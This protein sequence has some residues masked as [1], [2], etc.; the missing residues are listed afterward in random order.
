MNDK[1]DNKSS[2]ITRRDFFKATTI[3]ASGAMLSGLPL[4]ASAYVSPQET[5]KVALIGSGNRGAGAAVNALSTGDGIKLVAMADLNE[6]RLQTSYSHLNT[7]FQGTGKVDVPEEHKFVGFDAYKHAIEL[8]DVVLLC[9]YPAF[10]PL[11]F[12]EAVRQGKHVFAEKPLATDIKGVQKFFEVA[13]TAR[14]KKINVVVGLQRR[15]ETKYRE[16]VNRVHDGAIGDIVSGQ[17]YW[18][19]PHA[20]LQP[21]ERQPNESE[22]EYQIN[23]WYYF[24]WLSGGHIQDYNI[25]N[26]DAANWFVGE[27]PTTAQ[28]MGGRQVRSGKNAGDIFDHYSIEFT[29]PSGA[30]VSAQTRQQPG[31]MARVTERLQ[32]TRGYVETSSGIITDRN[33]SDIYR[34]DGEG[35]PNSYQ[36]ELDKLIASVRNGG[37]IDDTDH[38]INS[39]LTTIMGRMAAHSGQIIN[40]ED[41][42]N[43][44]INVMPERFAWDAEP[45]VKPDENGFYPTPI[46]GQTKVL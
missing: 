29:Y 42:L 46:P 8:A 2:G 18:L 38:G 27:F 28:G 32:G 43:S 15:Y 37:V 9:A 6:E 17:A 33:G 44:E 30:I 39:T 45:P 35:D 40:R 41:A 23:N 11:H 10:R 4:A 21:K 24:Y 14:Q 12:E 3:A 5:L 7:R 25:H 36:L 1:S 34:H 13:E 26:M 20:Y 19:T 31:T 22:M 16:L